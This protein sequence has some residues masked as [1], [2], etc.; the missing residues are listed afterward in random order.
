MDRQ[1]R[2][3]SL[4]APWVQPKLPC[5]VPPEENVLLGDRGDC[6]WVAGQNEDLD[7]FL[8]RDRALPAEDARG[9]RPRVGSEAGEP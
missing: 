9:A 5:R 6:H 8:A 3:C 1:P 4:G 7:N 2:H